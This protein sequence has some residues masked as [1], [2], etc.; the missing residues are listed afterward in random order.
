V[1]QVLGMDVVVGEPSL[2]GSLWVFPLSG[3]GAEQSVYLPGPDAFEQGLVRVNELDPPEVP[4]LVVEN[5]AAVALLL[6][7]GETLVGGNQNRTLN[8]TVLCP[9]KR[10]T[11]VPVSCVEAGRWGRATDVSRSR[12]HLPGSVRAAKTAD[13]GS[14]PGGPARWR[15]NQGRVW[16]EV[17][18]QAQRHGVESETAALE[19]V[20]MAVAEGTG[21]LLDGLEPLPGQ[22]GVA[23]ATGGR[24]LGIDVFDRP[25]TLRSY[26]KSLVAGYRLDADG[27]TSR[28]LVATVERF[29]A[30]VASERSDTGPGVGMGEEVR[31][32]GRAT[33]LALVLEGELV[34][35]AAFP[36]P[37]P[38]G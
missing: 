35:L 27:D 38:F 29:L 37:E 2:I 26:L 1:V 33:G 4:Y 23:C 13:L 8:T 10:P 30:E 7:E 6:V 22:V 25:A 24:V 5:L 31:L 12:S 18:R 20:Q 9:P 11:V 32:Q 14:V 28:T 15:S 36:Q 34:H 16:E 3:S 19:D 17:E 21:E